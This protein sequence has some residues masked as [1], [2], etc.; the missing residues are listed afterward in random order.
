MDVDDRQL[1]EAYHQGQTDAFGILYDRYI[2]KIYRFIFY[3]TFDSATAEDLTSSTFFKA[4]NKIETFDVARGNFSNW[5][6]SIARNSVIDHYRSRQFDARTGEDVFDLSEDNRLA[7]SLDAVQSLERVEDYL[8]TLTAS[9][10]EII[11]LRIWEER[12]YKE[13]AEIVGGTESSVKMSFSRI[14]RQLREDLG[15]LTTLALVLL[16]TARVTNL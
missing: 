7:D 6:Y 14:I 3:K 16:I 2:E 5:I 8:K 9:Q 11:I 13:I 1:L 12:S 15:P 4:L 10:R